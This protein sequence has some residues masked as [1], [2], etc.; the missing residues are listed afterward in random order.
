MDKQIIAGGFQSSSDFLDSYIDSG[1]GIIH[2]KDE[3][4]EIA[5]SLS[6]KAAL[7]EKIRL[8]EESPAI[9]V[10]LIMSDDSIL[11][12]ERHSQFLR[13][14]AE[15]RDKDGQLSREVNAL[16]QFIQLMYGFEKI[17]ISAVRGSV[18]G[19]FLGAILATD[20]RIASED[21]VFSLPCMEYELPPQGA[22]P[23]FLPR[24]LGISKAKEILLRGEPIPALYAKEL[25][26][27]DDV[28]PNCKYEEACIAFAASLAHLSVKVIGMTK[29]LLAWDMR[30]LEA[31]LQIENGIMI[32]HKLKPPLDEN[33]T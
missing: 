7:F 12:E 17:V 1:V 23:Y 5:T 8:A 29:R 21:T 32:A 10:L 6:L 20:F 14:T 31:Y 24:Y 3:V 30:G 13:E 16:S 26:L 4:F 33:G 22:L 19:A 2:L 28:V 18:V 11:G 27:L 15:S 25:G 9:N